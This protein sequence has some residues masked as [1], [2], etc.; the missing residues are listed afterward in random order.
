MTFPLF[1]FQNAASSHTK[2]QLNPGNFAKEAQAV[3]SS[4]WSGSL[5]VVCTNSYH[6]TLT[7]LAKRVGL[8]QHKQFPDLK[9]IHT[10]LYLYKSSPSPAVMRKEQ[11]DRYRL[12]LAVIALSL[13]TKAT[14]QTV[15]TIMAS[16]CCLL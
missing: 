2:A 5:F 15:G 13:K 9:S 11:S 4:A 10:R 8:F 3:K 1:V 6:W 7:P 12:L 14:K 16:P